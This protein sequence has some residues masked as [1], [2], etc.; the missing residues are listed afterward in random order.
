MAKKINK[1]N[2]S[3][4]K[5]IVNLRISNIA[6]IL[7]LL[8]ILPRVIWMTKDLIPKT[9]LFQNNLNF[10]FKDFTENLNFFNANLLKFLSI[11]WIFIVI[12]IFEFSKSRNLKTLSLARL[13]HS[14]GGKYADL[15]YFLISLFSFNLDI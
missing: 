14:N 1:N 13:K 5:Y 12:S 7:L 4:L 9:S 2:F 10:A 3:Y 11:T 15:I 8:A 6:Y